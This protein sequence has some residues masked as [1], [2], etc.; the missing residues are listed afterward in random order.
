MPYGVHMAQELHIWVKNEA[1]G[2]QD[3]EDLHAFL[4]AW[5]DKIR[6]EAGV[7]MEFS[8]E[9]V[10]EDLDEQFWTMCE[11]CTENH[12]P[13]YTSELTYLAHLKRAHPVEFKRDFGGK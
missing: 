8:V 5:G 7:D 4:T 12:R 2:F 11:Y 3:Q 9:E 6:R 1:D 13:M 10:A